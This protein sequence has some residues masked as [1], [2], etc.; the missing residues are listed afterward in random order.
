[1][2]IVPL[3]GH[4]LN[5]VGVL[6]DGVLF[7]ADA[8]F[9]E[10]VIDKY[11]VP[12]VQDVGSHLQMLQRLMGTR[13]SLYVPCHVEPVADITSLAQLNLGA[14]HKILEEIHGILAEPK[15][16]EEV[17]A[18]LCTLYGM[19]LDVVQQFYL[20]HT[21]VMAYLGYLHETKRVKAELRRNSL[22]WAA[23]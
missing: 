18:E 14:T 5:Q 22:Y 8:V 2:E 6:C 10:R 4:S 17:Q 12:V 23:A 16:S 3:P 15:T 21:T 11:R 13:H 9:S 7:C 19:D 20:I 1:V